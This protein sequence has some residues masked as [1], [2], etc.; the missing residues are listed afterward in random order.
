MKCFELT[1]NIL[2]TH[3]QAAIGIKLSGGLSV[4]KEASISAAARR[5]LSPFLFHFAGRVDT[6]DT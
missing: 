3:N 6:L 2:D 5:Y 1:L 4:R